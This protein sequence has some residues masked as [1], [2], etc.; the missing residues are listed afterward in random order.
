MQRT[1]TCSLPAGLMI[2]AASC[3]VGY[4]IVYPAANNLFTFRWTEERIHHA[5]SNGS[6]ILA[7]LQEY[8]D[9]HNSYPTTL[10][11]LIPAYL[12]GLPANPAGPDRWYYEPIPLSIHMRLEFA[13]NAD[14]YPCSYATTQDPRTWVRDE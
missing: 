12:Q 10:D 8:H 1:T 3:A 14:R 13:A 4:F 7:A 9:D 2:V 6:Q 11:M 5:Q